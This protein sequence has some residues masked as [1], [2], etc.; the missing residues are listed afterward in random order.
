ML[1]DVSTTV[2]YWWSPGLPFYNKSVDVLPTFRENSKIDTEYCTWNQ[3]PKEKQS[4]SNLK[5]KIG[6][7]KKKESTQ[8]VL[9]ITAQS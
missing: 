9:L 1:W 5:K 3:R 4:K 2:F 7:E 6:K 8:Y